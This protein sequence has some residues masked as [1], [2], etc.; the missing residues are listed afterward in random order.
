MLPYPSRRRRWPTR[1]VLGGH[2]FD[3]G[4]QRRGPEKRLMPWTRSLLDECLNRLLGQLLSRPEPDAA[5]LAASALQQMT[6]I[7]QGCA[8]QEEKRDPLWIPRDGEERVRSARGGCKPEDQ[9]VVAVVHELMTAREERLK[10][11]SRSAE[12]CGDCRRVLR[13]EGLDLGLGIRGI[14]AA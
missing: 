11:T 3:G 8:V 9:C 14:H 5:D 10:P 13:E 4:L 6:R 7:I 1:A 12:L 2:R